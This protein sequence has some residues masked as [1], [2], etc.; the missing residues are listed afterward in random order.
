L[1]YFGGA[2]R[3][4]A[5]KSDGWHFTYPPLL[6]I[7]PEA[8]EEVRYVPNCVDPY[9]MM[10]Y[11]NKGKWG[12]DKEDVRYEGVLYDSMELTMNCT[13]ECIVKNGYV[14]SNSTDYTGTRKDNCYWDKQMKLEM[15]V[16]W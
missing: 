3:S 13:C 11:R 4:A 6:Q 8:W 14:Y 9:G 16:V 2:N 7:E 1:D 12:V 5:L 10:A 15:Y